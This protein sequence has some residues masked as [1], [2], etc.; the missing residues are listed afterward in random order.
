MPVTHDEF[1]LWNPEP[2]RALE[3]ADVRQQVAYDLLAA[4]RDREHQEDSRF[5][6]RREDSLAGRLWLALGVGLW[7]HVRSLS[8]SA[9]TPSR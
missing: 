5:S 9:S 4:G 8:F 6:E 7:R 3:R 2:D 1:A